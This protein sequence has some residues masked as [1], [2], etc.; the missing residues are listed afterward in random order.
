MSQRTASQPTTTVI[1]SGAEREGAQRS[2][3]TRSPCSFRI[4]QLNQQI[5]KGFKGIYKKYSK[6][7]STRIRRWI[8]RICPDLNAGFSST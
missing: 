4:N 1:L 3:R 2:R 8:F 5:P 6:S 7:V